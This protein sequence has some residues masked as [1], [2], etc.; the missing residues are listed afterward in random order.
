MHINGTIMMMI[1]SCHAD[2]ELLERE[3][4]D[5]PKDRGVWTDV[6]YS[7]LIWRLEGPNTVVVELLAHANPH[8]AICPDWLLNFLIRKVAG[9]V[10]SNV[11]K[12]AKKFKGS[13]WEKRVEEKKE[14]YEWVDGLFYGH[15]RR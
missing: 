5:M 8:V 3:N 10:F 15:L 7:S 2:K 14:F 12:M 1:K 13:R 6:Y 9:T 11:V 4:I